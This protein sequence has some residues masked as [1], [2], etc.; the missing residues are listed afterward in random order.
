M[1]VV[2]CFFFSSRRR[3][4]SCALVTGVQTCALPIYANVS[5]DLVVG[6]AATIGGLLSGTNAQF[7]GDVSATNYWHLSDRRAK[8]DI[9]AVV[10]KSAEELRRL[11]PKEYHW[12]PTG[13]RKISYIAQDVPAALPELVRTDPR[14][15]RVHHT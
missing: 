10:C 6:D 11:L 3:H 7:S 1:N 4:T 2:R 15:P 9:Q 14:R 13:A 5:D 8:T 12:R